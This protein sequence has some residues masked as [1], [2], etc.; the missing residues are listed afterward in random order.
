MLCSMSHAQVYRC[1]NEYKTDLS[2]EDISKCRLVE[3]GKLEVVQGFKPPPPR[4]LKNA[5]D[6]DKYLSCRTDAAKAPTELGVKVG[7]DACAAKFTK[8]ELP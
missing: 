3:G 2:K 1:G 6:Y 8:L 7:L 5:A 4:V